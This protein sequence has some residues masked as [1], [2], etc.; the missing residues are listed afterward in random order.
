[1]EK[2]VP[3]AL[4]PPVDVLAVLAVLSVSRVEAVE[5]VL[6]IDADATEV[7][8]DLGATLHTV[9]GS[10]PVVSGE[11]R[12]D[13]ERGTASG[14]VVLD[15]RRAE[16]GNDRRDRK[17]HETVLESATYPEIVF[18]PGTA[19]GSLDAEGRGRLRVEGVVELHGGSHPIV[20]DATV[21]RDGDRAVGTATFRVPYVDWG[22]RDPS[23]FVLRVDKEVVVQVRA[24][25]RFRPGTTSAPE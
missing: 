23:A 14:A 1:M 17:M 2:G 20:L 9:H 11:L 6:E 4:R 7:S 12:F 5:R 21:E 22:L 8:F 19:T 18:R 25:G 3:K 24:V 16:T 10:I 15:A 13:L